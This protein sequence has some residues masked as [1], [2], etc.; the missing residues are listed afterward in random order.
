MPLSRVFGDGTE[1]SRRDGDEEGE[2]RE[3]WRRVEIGSHA[4]NVISFCGLSHTRARSSGNGCVVSKRERTSDLN[5]RFQA[6]D[7]FVMSN[8]PK[9]CPAVYRVEREKVRSDSEI[10]LE[11]PTVLPTVSQHACGC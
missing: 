1:K 3:T 8:G 9:C 7:A 2:G 10:Q 6:G 5:F 11:V 4:A